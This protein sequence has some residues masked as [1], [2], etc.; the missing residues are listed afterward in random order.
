MLAELKRCN[1]VGNIDGIIFLVSMLNGRKKVGFSELVNRCALEKR[2]TIHCSGAVAFLQYLGYIE[3]DGE[4]VT[5]TDKYASIDSK[6]KSVVI[7]SLVEECITKLTEE[8]LFDKEGLVFDAEQG[9]LSIRRSAF[10]L[11]YASI[12]NFLTIAGVLER[13][14]NGEI[15]ISDSYEQEFSARLRSRK[16]KFTL[17]QLMERQ[18]EQS[19]RGLEA[20]EF[21]VRFERNRIPLKAYKI[22]RISDFDV[23][24]GYDIVSFAD[25]SSGIYD[26]FIEVKSFIGTPHFYWSENEVDVA[27]LKGDR[28]VLCLVEYERMKDPEYEPIFIVNPY[29][30][31]FSDNTWLVNTSSYK[32]QKI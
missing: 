31:I 30:K 18:K 5:T 13:E 19:R 10:P 1:S 17:E 25:E 24:A 23:S 22:K 32:I 7:S 21:V 15:G 3:N 29:E 28:Y 6:E 27:K 4:I 26:R 2:V 12:R 16:D 14:F 20:E 11:A 8:G 9:H